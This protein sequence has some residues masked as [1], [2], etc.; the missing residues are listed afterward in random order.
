MRWSI[1]VV[2]KKIRRFLT[3][4][5]QR[6]KP[7]QS[8]ESPTGRPNM[9][10]LRVVQDGVEF[11]TVIATG[12]SGMSESGLGR[13]CGITQQSIS[14][15]L[16]NITTGKAKGKC[17]KPF[18]GDTF[19]LQARVK[20]SGKGVPVTIITADLCAAIIEYYAF[21]SSH[22]TQTALY[23]AQ[24]F[25][26]MGITKWIQGVTGWQPQLP[27]PQTAPEITHAAVSKYINDNI[28]EGFIPIAV[29]PVGVLKVIQ[30]SNFS[31]TG[32][33]L[34][35]YLQI[36]QVQEQQP[37]AVKICADLKISR[38]TLKK[39]LPKIQEW[40]DYASWIVFPALK[41]GKE[42]IIQLRLH[43][44]L[45]GTMEAPTPIGPV[46]LLT[47]TEI[48]EIKAIA[49]WK[50]AFGQVITKGLS[51]PNH[52]KR[53]H[54]FGVSSSILKKITAHCQPFDVLVTFEKLPEMVEA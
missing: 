10:I 51:Y 1:E 22:K 12:E 26:A 31:A 34:Y 53:I 44:E 15:L 52:I 39:T 16:Q 47:K 11:Y 40:G 30:E 2:Y 50:T 4:F 19:S 45:G 17:L 13:L 20:I 28:T 27:G 32:F 25:M 29:H 42:R 8:H 23:S 38:A 24:A 6:Q 14:D 21:E 33:R 7:S 46:D 43:K 41:M 9:S 48:I 49:D 35:W 18:T 37:E 36:M 3:L 5:K 54:L